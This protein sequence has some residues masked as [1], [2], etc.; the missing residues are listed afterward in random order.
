MAS[1]ATPSSTNCPTSYNTWS[2]GRSAPT[3]RSK[4][5]GRAS[6]HRGCQGGKV[7]HIICRDVDRL[8]RDT[9]LW[10]KFVELCCEH[11]VT[12]HTFS[13]PLALRSPSDRF[14]STVRAA[15]AQLEKDQVA[16]RVKRE[17][18]LAKQG[19]HPGGPA[20]FGYTARSRRAAE[21]V[22]S[23]VP[24]DQAR[25]RAEMEMPRGLVVDE[26]EAEVV[27][28]TFHLYVDKQRGCRWIAN[29]LNRLGHRR[30]SGLLWHPDKVRRVINNPTL[31]GKGP[32]DEQ[33]FE[34]GY[35]SRTPK[36]RQTLH[37]GRHEAIIRWTSGRSR[38][39]IKA[40]NRPTIEMPVVSRHVL[41]GRPAVPV[42]G[43]DD[44]QGRRKGQGRISTTSARNA[45]TTAA[46]R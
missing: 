43:G 7:R 26:K 17:R 33:F 29:E 32:Y 41:Y 16:D 25:S 12:I 21:L 35:G 36:Y 46:T 28:L 38:Q 6:P 5:P 44:H 14:T 30:R 13:G 3:C 11:G 20:P 19:K 9:A 4:T 45:S 39:R 23:G 18:E 15:A 27:K 8:S 31:A 10:L 1:R 37:E 34:A 24:A 22:A 42:R 2:N 40:R